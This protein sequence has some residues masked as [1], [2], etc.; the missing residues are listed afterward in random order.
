MLQHIRDLK[1]QLFSAL[2]LPRF[3]K[4]AYSLQ[5]SNFFTFHLSIIHFILDQNMAIN[6]HRKRSSLW[7]KN[8][9]IHKTHGLARFN[10]R[11]QGTQN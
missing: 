1:L 7:D 11:H 9:V 6:I 8:I 5:N 4:S 3:F 10:Y 2:L